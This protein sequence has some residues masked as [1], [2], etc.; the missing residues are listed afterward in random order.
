MKKAILLVLAICLGISS[1]PLFAKADV[2]ADKTAVAQQQYTVTFR[3]VDEYGDGIPGVNVMV[4]GSFGIG[5][6][7]DMDGYVSITVPSPNS[8]L[9]ISFVGYQSVEVAAKDINGKTITMRSDSE[10]LD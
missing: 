1:S 4:K 3:I 9:V 6:I 10:I 7:S 5:T 2:K 8:I